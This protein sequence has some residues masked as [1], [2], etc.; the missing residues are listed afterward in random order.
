MSLNLPKD[1]YGVTSPPTINDCP[2]SSSHL[3]G[4]PVC[5]VLG[6]VYWTS[7]LR[8][9]LLACTP[10]RIGPS[11]YTSTLEWIRL[12][13][14][15]CDFPV[16]PSSRLSASKVRWPELSQLSLCSEFDKENLIKFPLD[17]LHYLYNYYM[18]CAL[19]SHTY[20]VTHHVTS[21]DVTLWL[22]VMW[23]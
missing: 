18:V 11:L 12:R 14:W 23:P 16:I 10:M 7:S 2:Q 3:S 4:N 8:A 20:H 6:S 9:V 15:L 1:L 5:P 13:S 19:F 17:F 21:C 22:P